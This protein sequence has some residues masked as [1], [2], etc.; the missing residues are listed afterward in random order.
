MHRNKK[1]RKRRKTVIIQ[2]RKL[3][4]RYPFLIPR[5]RWTD[6]IA[7]GKRDK[8]SY[9]ELDDMDKGWR[10]AF[11]IQMCEEIRTELI[12]FDFLEKYRIMEIKEKFG[13]LRWYDNGIPRGSKVWDIINKYTELSRHTCQR[14]GRAAEIN[15]DGYWIYT[16]CPECTEKMNRRAKKYYG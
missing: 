1:E 10:K 3:C 16:M 7:W 9:T 14:C 4:K 2:N 11:G 15:N 8:Y 13:E 6:K 12:K 5:N